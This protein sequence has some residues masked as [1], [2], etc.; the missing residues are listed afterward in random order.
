MDNNLNLIREGTHFSAFFRDHLATGKTLFEKRGLDGLKQVLVET[1]R[2]GSYIPFIVTRDMPVRINLT[3]A[4]I[5]KEVDA[6][7]R[8][9]ITDWYGLA[10]EFSHKMEEFYR[11]RGL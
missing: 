2:S 10:G 6:R 4:Q 1:I 7:E 9:D 5:F 11:V 3:Y 8:V